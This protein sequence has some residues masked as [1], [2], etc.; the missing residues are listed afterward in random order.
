MTVSG[1]GF[2]LTGKWLQSSTVKSGITFKLTRF[3]SDRVIYAFVVD[4]E[5]KYIGIC[6]KDTT[7]L[8][9]RM[10]RYKNQQGDSTNKRISI[11]IRQC[12]A[13]NKEVQIF[14]LKPQTVLRYAGL[15]IDLVKALENPLIDKLKP[16]WNR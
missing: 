8:E 7:S 3:A 4:A 6:E 1:Y 12:L 9:D 2:S 11:K 5:P 14:A 15:N 13:D 10:G 16:E